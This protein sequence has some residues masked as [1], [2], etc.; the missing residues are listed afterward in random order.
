LRHRLGSPLRIEFAEQRGD[1]K[2]YRM[3]RNRKAARNRLV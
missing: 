2:L 3:D 1:V